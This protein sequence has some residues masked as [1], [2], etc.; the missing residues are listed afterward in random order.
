MKAVDLSLIIHD[1][2]PGAWRQWQQSS[3]VRFPGDSKVIRLDSMIAVA[4]AAERGLGVALVPM[5]LSDSW[6]ASG[7]LVALSDHELVTEDAYYFVYREDDEAIEVIRK[8]RSW[9]LQIFGDHR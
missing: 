2:R 4:R 9:V 1:T 8:L 6:F 5:H 7:S 3:G